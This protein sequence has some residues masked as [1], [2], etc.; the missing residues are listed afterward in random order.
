MDRTLLFLL[1]SYNLPHRPKSPILIS[2]LIS[3]GTSNR[4]CDTVHKGALCPVSRHVRPGSKLLEAM[5]L[6]Q[7]TDIHLFGDRA[8]C[9]AEWPGRPTLQSLSV[10]LDD[11]QRRVPDLGALVVSGDVADS[12]LDTGAYVTLR[13]ELEHR[14]LERTHICEL[15]VSVMR[16][17]QNGAKMGL[18]S[19]FRLW[20]VSMC[21]RSPCRCS[22]WHSLFWT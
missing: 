19:I 7:I 16:A 22:T 2:I 1:Q 3:L 17:S 21:R 9:M 18:W 8:G 11:I 10:V 14:G 4:V 6:V 12:G 5:K 15:R 20:R 13:R